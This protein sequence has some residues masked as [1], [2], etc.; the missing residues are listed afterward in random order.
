M[1]KLNLVAKIVAL[2]VLSITVIG[3]NYATAQESTIN[4]AQI[5]SIAVTANQIDVRYGEIALQK[6]NDPEVKK[7]AQNMVNDHN[8]VIKMAVE[9]AGKLGVTP[10]DNEV[11]QSLLAGE[12]E[13]TKMLQSKS[14]KEFNKAYIDNEVA[15]HQAVIDAVNNVLIPNAKNTELKAL[16]VKVAPVLQQHLEH[17]K[18]VQKNY[19]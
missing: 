16:L 5:A 15:Y 12:K 9:L 8:S 6:S 3:L 11:T 18:M 2:F 14:G 10:E 1:K 7:F 4:D 17:A 19:K 13:T